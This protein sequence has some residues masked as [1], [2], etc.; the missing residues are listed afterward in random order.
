MITPRWTDSRSTPSGQHSVATGALAK[1]I[2]ESEGIRGENRD[3]ALM[4][5]LIHDAGK[6]VIAANLPERLPGRDPPCRRAEKSSMWQAEQ[7]LFSATHAQVGA[8]L[9]GLWGLPDPI[10]EAVAFH[11]GPAEC[12]HAGVTPLLAVHVADCLEHGSGIGAAGGRLDLEHLQR[13]G[14]DERLPTWRKLH[15]EVM[16]QETDR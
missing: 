15:D 11:H 16:Q 5:G 10:I 3:F 9:F 8:Y 2:A 4:A 6:L 14:L 13:L 7:A 12:A 1:K